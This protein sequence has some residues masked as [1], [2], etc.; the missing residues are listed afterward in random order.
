MKPVA[1]YAFCLLNHESQQQDYRTIRLAPG[2]AF[3]RVALKQWLRRHNVFVFTF[4][5]LLDTAYDRNG[6]GRFIA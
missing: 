3:A 4:M 6:N 1:V 5:Q 2:G